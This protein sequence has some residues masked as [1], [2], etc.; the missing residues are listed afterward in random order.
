MSPTWSFLWTV[1]QFKIKWKNL[2]SAE[3][4]HLPRWAGYSEYR[5]YFGY[6]EY[7]QNKAE[8]NYLKEAIVASV[9]KCHGITFNTWTYSIFYLFFKCYWSIV[10]LQCVNFFCT[11]KCL[12]YTHTHTHTHT[13]I[14]VL[15]QIP[16]INDIIWY[17]SFS[18]LFCLVW[19][20]LSPSMLLEVALFHSF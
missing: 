5:I 9:K 8:N 12:S 3:P 19:Y 17:L 1:G 11:A 7:K 6:T 2:K 13:L 4:I 14:C 16:H 18:D 10:D 15:L 20:F